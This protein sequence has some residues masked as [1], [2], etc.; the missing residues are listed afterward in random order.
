MKRMHYIIVLF[1]L[2]ALLFGCTN[3]QPEK[4]DGKTGKSPDT[5]EGTETSDTKMP[6]E[7]QV[8]LE[9][10]RLATTTSLDNSGLLKHIL[11]DFTRQ[12][13]IAVD[14]IAVGTG[15]ALQHG[16]DGDV[17][18][19]LVH[20]PQSELQYIKDDWALARM[21]IC[22][23]EFVIIGPESDPAGLKEAKTIREAMKKLS[24]S[25]SDFI[26]RG[27]NSGT[28]KREK[29]V[30]EAAGIEPSGDW[31]KPAGQGMGAVL[32][33]ANEQQAYTLTDT[34]TYYSM[35]DKL[36]L[37]ILFSGDAILENVYSVLILNPEIHPHLKQLEIKEFAWWI[38]SDETQ[39][40]ISKFKVNGHTL[41]TVLDEPNYI[42]N[43]D[44]IE[45]T[46]GS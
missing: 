25:K 19:V 5:V 15:K 7:E 36:N 2:T 13:G 8:I 32:T 20:A 18:V 26:S 33:M 12:T 14:V 30:W 27:D 3:T 37:P 4:P 21:Y 38:T 24:N 1:L 34:G 16:R 22:Q 39:E 10:I 23:N 6:D 45:N 28:H 35:I 29:S 9:T 41:F 43:P 42:E 40:I 46:P 17:D 44:F 11:P 31:Y